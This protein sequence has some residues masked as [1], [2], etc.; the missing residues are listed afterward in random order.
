MRARTL[1]LL[2]ALAVLPGC[3]CGTINNAEFDR[4]YPYGRGTQFTTRGIAALTGVVERQLGGTA[5]ITSLTIYPSYAS[6]TAESPQYAG[7]YDD[8]QYRDG[9]IRATAVKNPSPVL[10]EASFDLR[11]VALDKLPDL[12]RASVREV[13]LVGGRVTQ[14]HIARDWDRVTIK[15]FCDDER[16]SGTVEYDAAGKLIKATRH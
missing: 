9:R 11:E 15:L 4:R 5:R 10:A 16:H 8:Y 1:T 13:D 12:L 6:F 14:V 2:L 7:E 3:S